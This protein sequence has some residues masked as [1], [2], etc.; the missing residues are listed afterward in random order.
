VGA[1]MGPSA[2]ALRS[3]IGRAQ[4]VALLAIAVSYLLVWPV[5]E[6]AIDDDWAYARS[7]QLLSNEGVLRI[8]D[9]N[10][11]TLVGHLAWGALFTKPLGFSFTLAKASTVLLLAL[12]CFALIDVLR[13]VRV[14]ESWIVLAVLA[15]IL[16]PLHFFQSF[17]YA[18][19]V[20][21]LA[22]IML[23]LAS[24][25]R[26]LTV[27]PS[28]SWLPF[29]VGSAFASMAWATRQPGILV[30]LALLLHLIV[31]DRERLMRPRV[32]ASFLLPALAVVGLLGWYEG[33]HGATSANRLA[34]AQIQSRLAEMTPAGLLELAYV[35]TAYLVL[36][37][38]PLLVAVRWRAYLPASSVGRIVGVALGFVSLA[39]FATVTSELGWFPYL[40]NK[41]TPFG[42]F[43]PNEILV[44]ARDVWWP[45]QASTGVAVALLLGSF[46]LCGRVAR[47]FD[48]ELESSPP[49][50]T[51]SALRF[52]AVVVGLQ[53]LYLVLTAGI[54]FDR[55]LL[56]V[57]PTA[58]VLITAS[59]ARDGPTLRAAPAIVLLL[60]AV[61]SVVGTQEI[62]AMS[63]AAFAAGRQLV[64]EG[65]DPEYIEAGYAFDG[66]HMYE[67]SQA[68]RKRPDFVSHARR[69]DI[70]F[71][72][73]LYPMILSRY[74]VSTS[75]RMHVD[76]W[77]GA[78]RPSVRRLAR[79]P[80]LEG[81]RVIRV[82]DYRVLWPPM[83]RQ[84]FVLDDPRVPRDQGARRP[85]GTP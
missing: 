8:L 1:A 84:L 16:H 52:V 14:G 6:Y 11:M 64:D 19:D 82:V 62:H 10:P 7:L 47:A 32:L 70:W 21:M 46:A 48:A 63:R 85:S 3:H 37:L 72:R 76:D 65:V 25:V 39:G 42:Y 2:H 34:Q 44:G 43:I 15:L 40:R 74:L 27:A 71:V 24:Y 18:T 50:G 26:G 58:L 22:W 80:R 29:L 41:L 59:L 49:A 81:R 67:R 66:W 23:A 31:F 45:E 4:V 12:E 9:W 73:S 56:L 30:T 17:L 38:A 60:W 36:F 55:H 28:R 68:A 75:T 57:F 79:T 54:T 5:G 51:R 77:I 35:V 53:L 20:P 33:V 78:V 13:R 69:S 83:Q 61:Y